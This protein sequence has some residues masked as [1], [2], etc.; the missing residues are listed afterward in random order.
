PSTSRPPRGA[1][2][3]RA[4]RCAT[5]GCAACRH[6][7]APICW[8]TTRRRAGRRSGRAR[9]WRGRGGHRRFWGGRG[10][11]V[12]ARGGGRGVGRGGRERGLQE[13]IEALPAEELRLLEVL[14]VAGAPVPDA[15]LGAVAEC[16][17]TE[18]T[19]R[20]GVL[21]RARLIRVL[22]RGDT[23]LVEPFHDR[24]REAL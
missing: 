24:I 21:R 6:R 23:R 3:W 20:I 14:A 10:G 8:R 12:G 22:R 7:R 15:L 18:Y 2:R 11:A 16:D 5:C 1:P 9:G 19:L 4:C 13:R 17:A